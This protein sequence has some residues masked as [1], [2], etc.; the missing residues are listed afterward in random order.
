VSTTNRRLIQSS[1]W[2]AFT[3]TLQ[4]GVLDVVPLQGDPEPSIL[5]GNIADAVG[6]ACR[7]DRP[8]VRRGWLEKGPGPDAN[9]GREPFVP[10]SWDK[11]LD[12]IAAELVRVRDRCGL[13]AI[14]GG[15]YGW[16]SAGRF[17]HAQSQLHRFLNKAVGGYTRSVGNYSA[18]AAQILAPFI[19]GNI[20]WTNRSSAIWAGVEADCDLMV[21]FGG[22]AS[23]NAA[24]SSGG[25]SQ[26]TVSSSIR[27]M[28]ERGGRIVLVSPLRSDIDAHRGVEWLPVR[29]LSDVALMLGLAHVLVEEDLLDRTFLDSH[30]EGFDIFEHYLLGLAGGPALDADWAASKTGIAASSIRDLARQ[31]AAGRTLVTVSQSLQRAEH[32]EQ[33]VW[34]A[35]AL[36]AMLGQI[37]LPG[38]GFSYGLGSLANVGKPPLAVPLPTLPQGINGSDSFIPVARIADMLLNPGERYRY[39]GETRVYPDIRLVY[40]SGGNPFH[41]H[42]DLNRLMKAFERP[43]TVIVHEPYWTAS[44]RRA[45]I[46]LPVSVTLE[47][48][49]IGAAAND[50]R[51][52]AMRRVVEPPASVRD[53]YAIYSELARRLGRELEFTEGRDIDEW[54]AHLYGQTRAALIDLGLDAPDFA[55][56][57]ERGEVELPV[58]QD[59]G[60]LERFRADPVAAPLPTPSGRLEIF[61]RT[62]A[63]FGEA[64]CPGHPVWL[65]PEEW[66]G[67]PAAKQFPIQ[68][69]ANQPATRLHSQLDFGRISLAS[70]IKGREPITLNAMDAAERDI[71]EGDVVLVRNARG[72]FLAGA[73]LSNDLITGVAQI[74]TGAWFDPRLIEGVGH[75]CVHGNPNTVTRDVGTSALTQGSTGQLCLIQIERFEGPLPEIRAHT[76]PEIVQP[77]GDL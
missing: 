61:S 63:G 59:P 75:V 37:G 70:K 68:L 33:P 54:L 18:G 64:D 22:M 14:Y 27:R 66:L 55:E 38:G 29:P 36:A 53:E 31:M 48:D 32:G 58:L 60:P 45:D 39:R 25:V 30:C 1:H 77:D 57:V 12:L 71:A 16:S 49:D 52:F 13:D 43:D 2:G 6:P 15:S 17:H 19:I 7:I 76:P 72:A 69:I 35:F 62:I 50:P 21:C 26:H 67:A 65:E 47:R 28:L 46:V 24:V 4:G 74:A 44:A 73:R 5:I 42:Q 40:W 56:F 20:D 9:R 41:H 10:I 8:M 11:A 34:A 23:K 51:M 3:A